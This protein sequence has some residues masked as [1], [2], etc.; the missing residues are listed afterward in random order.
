MWYAA[1]I[2]TDKMAAARDTQYPA[3]MLSRPSQGA[4]VTDRWHGDIWLRPGFGVFQGEAGDTMLHAHCAHQIV[5]ARCGE[6]EVGFADCTVR[7]RGIAIPANLAH[8]MP[9][10]KVLLIYLDPWTIE[11]RALF[12]T[13]DDIYKVLSPHLCDALMRAVRDDASLR[14]VLGLELGFAVDNTVDARFQAARTVLHASIMDNDAVS[15]ASMAKLAGLS[16]GR[17]SHWFAQQAGLPLR[18][19]RKWLRLVVAFDHIAGGSNLTQAAHAAGFADSAHMS[20]TFRQM[21]GVNP[22]AI[23]RHVTL[24]RLSETCRT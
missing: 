24:H 5:I 14:R 7:V 2:M 16:P 6:V 11:A 13:G 20:R 9:P 23:F 15:R 19:Y 22:S 21:F 4:A 3:G 10:S 17:F 18:S 8:R 1:N 12:H